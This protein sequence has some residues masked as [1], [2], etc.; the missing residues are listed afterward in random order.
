MK[1]L[2]IGYGSIG[3]RHANNVISLGHDVILLRHTHGA[4]NRE[5]F[6]EYY[7]FD[8]L[9]KS[10]DAPPDAAIVCSPTSSHLD[11][12]KILVQYG[13]PFLLEKPPT[14]D[15]DSAK[16]L[17]NLLNT[18]GFLKYDIAYNLRYHP[19]LLF[20]KNIL[21]EV[22]SV[23]STRVYV[24]YYLPY[25]RD[26][27]DYRQTISAKKELGGGVHVE[28]A[29]EID[30]LLWMLGC[31]ERVTG[32][33]NKASKLE[34]SS[35]DMCSAIFMFHDGSMAELHMDYLSHRYLRGGQIIAENGTLEWD[36]KS[37]IVTYYDKRKQNTEEIFRL[38]SD[39]DLND[40]YIKELNNFIK[41]ID[42]TS[43]HVVNI[44][45]ALDTMK[46][47]A[48]IEA[49]TKNESWVHL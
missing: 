9:L 49:S 15:L 34:I 2:I 13:I 16:E 20:I 18:K 21:P 45:I 7:S 39:Y 11:N 6:R 48:A 10:N 30:Y 12:I 23:Y 41:I 19:L 17:Q 47:L 26:G 37:G 29:H 32:F 8:E 31:P 1:F 40:T 3:K 14:A 22:G 25:W 42:G 43:S 28:L 5:G 24:G 4:E 27:I 36:L 44:D 38:P 33:A 46:V 35:E